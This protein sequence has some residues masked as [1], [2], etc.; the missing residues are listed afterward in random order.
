MTLHETDILVKKA[1]LGSVIGIIC[2]ILIVILVRVGI[3]VKNY[4]F[5]PKI[6]P[7]TRVYGLLPPLQMPKNNFE[8]KFTY[9]IQTTTGE[10]PDALPDRLSI[11]PI[12]DTPPNFLNLDKV[13]KKV[14]N[15]DITG[16]DHN[17]VPEIQ[18]ENPFYEWDEAKDY[19]RRI[20]FNINTLDFKLT[21]DYLTSL[22][23]LKAQHIS[24][25]QSAINTVLDFLDTAEL[26]PKDLDLTK[27]KVPSNP[28]AYVTFPQLF[29]IQTDN[30]GN[31]TLVSTTSLSKTKTIRIDLYQKDIEYVMKTGEAQE[32]KPTIEI[33]MPI[34]YPEPPFSTM[35]FWVAS[36]R[37]SPVVTQAFYTHR[38][39]NLNDTTATYKIKTIEQAYTELKNHQAYIASYR[40]NENNILLKN[41][42]LAYYLGENPQQYLMPIYVFEGNNGFFAYISAV[43]EEQ[44]QK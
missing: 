1:G 44:I 35:S 30:L 39:I 5:P 36:G 17:L 24:D 6:D 11:F 23:V 9:T 38:D 21:S 16:Q 14:T 34:L 42:F 18:L 10:L 41:I 27:T 2:I 8:G 28:A 12:V 3:M 22:T 26:M 43:E 40:G 32:F 20:I 7:P 13:K 37:S 29:D 15:L 31:N 25:E 33:K 19:N 4:Y